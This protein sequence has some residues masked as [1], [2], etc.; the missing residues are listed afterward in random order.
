MAKL[1]F[2]CNRPTLVSLMD[3]GVDMSSVNSGASSADSENPS[4]GP[5]GEKDKGEEHEHAPSIKG[6][7]GYGKGRVVFHLNMNVDTV[8][9]FL[10]KEDGSQLAMFVQENFLLDFKVFSNDFWVFEIYGLMF[11]MESHSALFT[12]F[13][14]VNDYN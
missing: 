1:E 4:D 2:Y 10:N 11:F 8:T 14:M 5:S 12:F 7:L 3:F 6:L 9:M 13:D